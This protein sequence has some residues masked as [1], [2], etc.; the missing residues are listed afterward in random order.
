MSKKTKDLRRIQECRG[1]WICIRDDLPYPDGTMHSPTALECALCVKYINGNCGGCPINSYSFGFGCEASPFR[2]A[3]DA[4]R[5]LDYVPADKA[6]A[7]INYLDDV[8][9]CV[10]TPF[11]LKRILSWLKSLRH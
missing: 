11:R 4:Y 8:E 7:M 2:A 1:H 9:A 5:K 3:F 6:Q 10:K